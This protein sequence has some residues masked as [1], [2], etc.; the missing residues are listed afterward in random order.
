V[1]NHELG[2][3]FD[4]VG[5]ARATMTVAEYYQFLDA[6]WETTQRILKGHV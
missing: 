4:M 2:W 1:D 5:D 6:G 3:L